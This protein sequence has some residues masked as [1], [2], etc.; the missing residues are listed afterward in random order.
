MI[1][2]GVSELGAT[3]DAYLVDNKGTVFTETKEDREGI[4]EVINTQISTANTD[5]LLPEIDNSNT[6]FAYSSQYNNYNG[7]SVFGAARVVPIGNGYAGLIMEV[8]QNEAFSAIKQLAMIVLATVILSMIVAA[9]F[10]FFISR[11]ISKPL[12]LVVNFVKELAHYNI[13][14]DISTKYT[15]RKDEIGQLASAMHFVGQNLREMV[16]QLKETSELLAASSEE[17]TATSTASGLAS[18]EVARAISEISEGAS[19]QA[20]NTVS[21]NEKLEELGEMIEKEE[22]RI[23]DLMQSSKKISGLVQAGLETV[24]RLT[25][26]TEESSKATNEVYQSIIKTNDSSNRISDASN[27][28]KEIA[29]QTN[30]LALNAAI[31]AARAGEAGKGFAVVADE[32]RKLAIQ[33]TK[34]T[35]QIDEMVETLL[36]DAHIAVKTMSHVEKILDEQITYVSDAK[37]SYTEIA[38]AMIQ[39]EQA[40]SII[41]EESIKVKQHKDDVSHTIQSLAAVAQE[42]AAA[43]EQASNSVQEQTQMLEEITNASEGLSTLANELQLLISKFSV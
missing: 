37:S 36:T 28:I 1:L 11:S 20:I 29:E 14:N 39:S 38:L 12:S 6:G 31:E 17:L 41:S 25:V 16:R 32:I 34:S 4:K 5:E 8:D 22:L 27:L 13:G 35:V 9:V 19:D 7:Q 18:E 10:I 30:L 33:S 21:G 40:V 15:Q 43:T 42:N 24:E 23:H 3:G 26:K 2:Q